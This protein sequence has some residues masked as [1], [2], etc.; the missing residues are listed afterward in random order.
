MPV[1]QSLALA[2]V[3]MLILTT[4]ADAAPRYRNQPIYSS[5]SAPA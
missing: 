4:P 1:P 5:R 3:L 2:S